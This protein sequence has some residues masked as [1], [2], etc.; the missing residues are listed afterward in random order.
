MQP[1][2]KNWMPKGMVLLALS[3]S[4]ACLILFFVFN[5][6]EMPSAGTLKAVLKIVFLVL[7]IGLAL[8]TI[9]LWQLHRAFSYNGTR[10]MS[11]QIIEGVSAYITILENGK[12]LDVGCGSGALTIAVAKRNTKAQVIGVDRWGG[13]YASYSRS[14]CE[15]NAAAEG[16]GNAFFIKGNALKLDFDNGTFDAVFSN[17]VYHNIPSR[18]RQAILLETLRVLKKGGTF[19][20]HDIFARALYGDMRNFMQKLKDIGYEKVEMIDT[21]N[22]MFMTPWEATWMFCRGSAILTGKK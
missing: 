18:N 10:Q 20:I 16:V 22:G 9:W 12:G 5:R 4:V 11:K 3:G 6:V 7:C 19:T 1:D 17:Y 15:E 8:V 13:E 2:Y 21:T 14:L